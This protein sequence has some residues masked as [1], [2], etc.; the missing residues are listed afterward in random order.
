VFFPSSVRDPVVTVTVCV[1][2]VSKIW[3]A[4]WDGADQSRCIVGE[5]DL[6]LSRLVSRP[7]TFPRIPTAVPRYPCDYPLVPP[8]LQ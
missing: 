5:S 1:M 7:G 2:R 4:I 8:T 6:A 3:Y